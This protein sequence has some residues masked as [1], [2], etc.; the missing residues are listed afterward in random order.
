MPAD[1]V[2]I[3]ADIPDDLEVK[4]VHS[5]EL[6]KDWRQYPAPE[7]LAALGNA[8]IESLESAV[9]RIPSAVIPQEFNYLLNPSHPE[10]QR[11]KVGK[12]EPF[13]FDP[14]MWKNR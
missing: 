8:W 10:F 7:L 1:F 9:L 11:I 6:P 5:S 13:E 12:P 3:F 14:R 4:L 2:A